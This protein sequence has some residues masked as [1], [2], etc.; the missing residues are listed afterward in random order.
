[1][2]TRM[3]RRVTEPSCCAMTPRKT[4]TPPSLA[5]L[6]VSFVVSMC[7]PASC[8][9][10]SEQHRW[11]QVP[12]LTATHGNWGVRSAGPPA[13]SQVPATGS[14]MNAQ[15]AL[16]TSASSPVVQPLDPQCPPPFDRT[17]TA[18]S[19]WP[20]T[21]GATSAQ[22]LAAQDS[23]ASA[24][25]AAPGTVFAG[26]DPWQGQTVVQPVETRTSVPAAVLAAL[27]AR[28]GYDVPAAAQPAPTAPAPAAA[29]HQRSLQAHAP[30]QVSVSAA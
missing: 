7:G 12:S 9:A 10:V 14:T 1:M 26:W 19:T 13:S 20:L 24:T 17:V 16:S 29:V 22:P 30:N 18:P 27:S 21:S 2:V 15:P 5:Y 8:P 23:G 28:A 11:L 3:H 25:I 6:A 4:R